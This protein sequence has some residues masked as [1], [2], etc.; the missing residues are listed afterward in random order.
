MVEVSPE[1]LDIAKKYIVELEKNNFHIQRAIL[2]GSHVNGNPHPWSD[3]DVAV[4]S[5][6][7]VGDRFEDRRKI[8]RITLSV[9]SSISPKTYRPEDFTTENFFVEEILENGISI[10]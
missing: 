3:I 2:F 10:K 6:D 4:V 9:H 1:I 7:F 5:E 8:A